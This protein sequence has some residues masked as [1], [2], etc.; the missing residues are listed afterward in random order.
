MKFISSLFPVATCLVMILT[1]A[2]ATAQAEAAYQL[3]PKDADTVTVSRKDVG[4]VDLDLRFTVFF[5][6]GSPDMSFRNASAGVEYTMPSWANKAL[7]GSDGTIE[8]VDSFLSVGDGFDPSVLKGSKDKRTADIFKSSAWVTL[9]ASKSV[10]TGTGF[11]FTFPEHPMF[12]LQAELSLPDPAAP[13]VLSYRLT[14]KVKGYYSVG[15]MGAPAH[16]LESVEDIW[17]PLVWQEKRFPVAS[18]MTL[19]FRCP[20]PTTLVTHSGVTL[21]IVVDPEEFPFEPLPGSKN[22]RFGVTVRNQQGLAQ[23]MTFAPVLGSVG[24]EMAAGESFEFKL[25]PVLTKGNTVDAFDHI[26]TSLYGVHDYR[27]NAI[28]SLNRTLVSETERAQAD[29]RC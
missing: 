6:T 14:P 4:E 16:S 11:A 13:P 15:Y 9:S 24:S 18:F 8:Q 2:P 29:A 10:K 1:V 25:R 20:P 23:P 12:E 27:S 28:G 21:G 7:K 5:A 17:Q 26:A 22:S 3:V 19:A